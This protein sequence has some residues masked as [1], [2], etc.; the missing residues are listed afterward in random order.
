[1]ALTT[2][3]LTND[4]AFN[5]I[6]HS[7]IKPP[8]LTKITVTINVTTIAEIISNPVKINVAIHITNNEMPSENRTSFHIFKYC[9]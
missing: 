7:H 1:M 3:R 5:E 8:I 4:T 2:T 6:F 9:S